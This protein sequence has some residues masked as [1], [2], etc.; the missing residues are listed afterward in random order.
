MGGGSK[1]AV[2]GTSKA[3]PDLQTPPTR[4]IDVAQ[5][6]GLTDSNFYGGVKEKKFILEMTGNGAAMVDLDNDTHPDIFLVNGARLD[7]S[8]PTP[9][10]LYRNKGDGT[11]APV[12]TPS[13][14]TRSGWGQG[15]CAGD[16]DNDG[17]ADLLVT[18]YGQS[19]LYRNLGGFRFEDVTARMGL[20]TSGPKR[21][22]TGCS[23]LDYDRDGFLDL[24]ISNYVEFNIDNAALPG[25]SPFCS[26]KGLRVFCGPRGFA[27][28]RNILYHNQSGRA[29]QDVSKP[30]GILL[31]GLHYAL[32]VVSS[33]F[34]DD[35]WPDIYVSCDSTPSI[36]YRNN[37]D[38]T[39]SDI[40]VPRG[41]AY[42]PDGQEQGSMGVAAADYDNDGHLDIVKTNFI[43]ETPTLYR[44]QGD[45]Y[46]EDQTYPAGLG[47]HNGFVGWGVSF[48]DFDH[49]GWK[50]ILM[51]NGHIYPELATASVGE[52]FLQ[53]KLLFWNLRNGAFRDITSAAGPSLNV[54][55]AS[56]GLALADIDSDGKLEALVINMNARP[57][58]LKNTAPAANALLVEAEGVKSNRSAI[59][60]RVTVTAG[61][62][63]QTAEIQSGSSYASQN[64]FTLHFGLAAQTKADLIEVRWPSG[65]RETI[66]GIAANQVIHLREGQGLTATRPLRAPAATALPGTPTAAPAPAA[67]ARPP[68]AR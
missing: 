48:F 63:K 8:Q 32:G 46:F 66:R 55:Q 52:A 59:G 37:H 54:P 47:I 45:G 20:A 62:L 61:S 41:A 29:F 56:R 18:Y 25:A 27:T 36:L 49:D 42:G 64:D 17:L 38:G 15:V 10:R 2:R 43:G 26:W 12:L 13:P 6:A 23:F 53:P 33:D 7:K 21:W 24:V 16:F 22:N 14:L 67:P 30:A 5:S 40:A 39:F 50:D 68:A 51:A 57:S 31:D 19:A 44:A 4:F 1:A 58:L 3:R 60:A 28:D 65:Q 11:F 9:N 35:G 34:D